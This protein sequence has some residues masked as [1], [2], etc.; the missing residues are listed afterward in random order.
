M[1]PILYNRGKPSNKIDDFLV[2][3]SRLDT[4]N[5]K[6]RM[7]NNILFINNAKSLLLISGLLSRVGYEVDLV[8]DLDTGLLKLE[9]Q[10]YDIIIL[11]ESPTEE[12][13]TI[14]ARIRN[15]TT[16]P[17]IVISLNA[18]TETCIKAIISGAD[19]F[20]RKPFGPQELLARIYSLLQRTSS[21]QSVSITS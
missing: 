9:Q 4:L 8:N 11:L 19:Y 3:Y 7:G 20:L 1:P 18:S 12:S 5:L 13:W 6:I 16:I 15:Q 14:C 2:S 21:Q 17:L 10:T